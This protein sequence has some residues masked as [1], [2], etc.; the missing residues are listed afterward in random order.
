MRQNIAEDFKLKENKH[1]FI[2]ENPNGHVVKV[3][4]VSSNIMR[5]KY[6]TKEEFDSVKDNFFSQNDA[7][8]ENMKVSSV[9]EDSGMEI[10]TPNIRLV[11]TLKPAFQLSWYSIGDDK[12]FAQDLLYR[13]YGYD[14]STS[15][16]WHYQRKFE[17]SF[18]YG[19]GERSGSIDLSGRRFRLERLDCMGYDAETSDPLY[20][21]CPFYI[22]LS[23]RTKKAYGVYYNNFSKTTI[24]VGQEIDAVNT[25]TTYTIAIMMLFRI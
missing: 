14:K 24:D 7:L 25:I 12:L 9:N 5:V 2:F 22:N 19:L 13:S 1:P 20:K 17:D 23:S 21:F 15:E 16:K 18:Y 10:E 3:M 4:V 11:I 8:I 6:F